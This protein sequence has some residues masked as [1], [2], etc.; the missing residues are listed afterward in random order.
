MEPLTREEGRAL[1]E[2]RGRPLEP[3]IV[4]DLVQRAEGNPFF[5]EELARAVSE[6]QS[7][8]SSVPETIQA[9]VSA[10][11]D[12]LPERAK[13]LLLAA[14]VVGREVPLPLLEAI[15]DG[16]V[17][18]DL[19]PLLRAEFVYDRLTTDQPV[20]EFRHA[21]MQEVA[22]SSLPGARRR[23]YH[24]AVGI[25]LERLHAGH[26]DHVVELLAQH[27]IRSNEREKG[28][29]YCL[30]AAE[31]ARHRSA[32]IEALSFF[33]AATDE[34]HMLPPTE[35]NAGRR[36][37]V[38]VKQA[39]V[40]FALG[41]HAEHISALEAIAELIH[42]ADGRRQASWYFWLSFMHGLTG[43]RPSIAAAECR[44]AID[45]AT[46]GGF[47]DLLAAAECCL[48]QVLT[49]AGDLSG[50]LA[51]GEHALGL[52]EK[53]YDAPWLCRTLWVTAAA[54]TARGDWSRAKAY[55][56]RALACGESSHDTR[57]V[58]NAWWRTAGTLVAQGDIAGCLQCCQTALSLSP[59]PFDLASIRGVQGYAHAKK[60]D[61]AL[62]IPD[63]EN[64]VT[65]SERSGVRYNWSH[66]GLRLAEAYIRHGDAARARTL[67]ERILV[68]DRDSGYRYH[69]A[70]ALRLLGGLSLPTNPVT[71]EELLN[72]AI[73]ICHEIGALNDLACA[74]AAKAEVHRVV[75]NHASARQLLDRSLEIFEEL[76]TLDGPVAVRSALEHL[77]S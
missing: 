72:D 26:S 49:V 37:D 10:R 64:A 20:Y 33:E 23:L 38:I 63:L 8:S 77:G 44:T 68:T 21:L 51:S 31:K 73:D 25:A 16:S 39:E 47:D 53:L 5:L 3:T 43:T 58:V 11:I 48:A 29:D 19:Q 18:D 36:I 24:G 7:V 57:L 46:K 9:V 15:G 70:I 2:S 45:I 40:K 62:G 50:A 54:A 60:G 75:G 67:L 4:A 66:F 35:A 28:V 6:L 74:F 27:F 71:A 32:H 1:L 56:A 41:R 61:L 14:S 69:E 13:N 34:L 65:A 59:S 12:R 52:F 22:Y 76:G 55:Y 17:E 42:A 30:L